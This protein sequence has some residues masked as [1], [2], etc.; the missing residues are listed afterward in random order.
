MYSCHFPILENP[1]SLPFFN[2][3]SLYGQEGGGARFLP[4]QTATRPGSLIVLYKFFN[5]FFQFVQF[6]NSF[7]RPL[8]HIVDTFSVYL[9]DRAIPEYQKLQDLN[10][11]PPLPPPPLCTVTSITTGVRIQQRDLSCCHFSYAQT[12]DQT[13]KNTRGG[14]TI[15]DLQQ[16][17]Q[18]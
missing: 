17:K 5:N 3:P 7:K 11:P 9:Q 13:M 14:A 18:E 4:P 15:E 1:A 8:I 10:P 6:V 12:K 2:P 16:E